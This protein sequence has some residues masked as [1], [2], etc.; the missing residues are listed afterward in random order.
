MTMTEHAKTTVAVACRDQGTLVEAAVHHILDVAPAADLLIV[1]DWCADVPTMEALGRL[2]DAGHRVVRTGTRGCASTWNTAIATAPEAS[3]IALLDAGDCLETSF[4][5]TATG[6]LDGS[7][8]PSFVLSVNHRIGAGMY[9]ELDVA[10]VMTHLS[11][12]HPAVLRRSVWE[13]TRG[14]DAE[15]GELTEI[16][17]W[18]SALEL[19]QRG[20]ALY[21]DRV[22][23]DRPPVSTMSRERWKHLRERFYTKHLGSV[24]EHAESI[25][26]AQEAFILDLRRQQEYLVGRAHHLECEL[27]GLETEVDQTIKEL[28]CH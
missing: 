23:I 20:I 15:L 1:D 2:E 14:F 12:H 3:Y 17:C 7:S 24:E 16:D 18:T 25:F 26:T 9:R 27:A 11:L 8:N 19:G 5:P 22:D 6:L 10:D 4:L 28:S 13:R 21:D